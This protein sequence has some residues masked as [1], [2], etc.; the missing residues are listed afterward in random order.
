MATINYYIRKLTC[1][2][3]T[4]ADIQNL[5]QA[6]IQSESSCQLAAELVAVRSL[7]YKAERFVFDSLRNE[8]SVVAHSNQRETA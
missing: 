7:A 1:H 2:D 4:R 3:G 8:R 5:Q 6:V